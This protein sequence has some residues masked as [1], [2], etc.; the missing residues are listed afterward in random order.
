[1][2]TPNVSL[3]LPPFE[4][5]SEWPTLSFVRDQVFTLSAF[6]SVSE[7][8]TLTVSIPI[9]PGDSLTGADGEIEWNGTLWGPT[10]DV[11]VL[12]P[13]EGWLSMPGIDNLNVE[14]PTQHG[15]WDARKLAQQRIVSFQLQPNSRDDPTQVQTLIDAITSATGIP[16]S[17]DPLPLV[18]KAYGEPKLA[19]GQVIARPLVLDGDYNV[20][21]PT[22]GVVIACGDPRLYGLEPHGVTVAVSTPTAIANAGNAATHPI[23]RLEGPVTNPVLVNST[24]GRTLQFSIVVPEGEILE[25]VTG[26]G[27]VTMDGDNQMSTLAGSSVPVQDFVLAAGSNL[28]TYTVTSGGGGGADFLWRDATL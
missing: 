15:A 21:L 4:S 2:T 14:K 20:G 18:I 27:T 10:T 19:F 3:F 23:I 28:I 5:A 24:L 25:I 7:W 17:E 11:R 9:K 8:P 26:D 12:V 1:M 6:E 13:V 22:V 16:E